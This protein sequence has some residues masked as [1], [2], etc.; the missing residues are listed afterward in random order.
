[1]RKTTRK[2][3]RAASSRRH[4]RAAATPARASAASPAQLLGDIRGLIEAA[5]MQTAQ[6]VNAGLVT[7]CWNIGKRIREDSLREKRAGY[8]EEIVLTLS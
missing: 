3:A 7:L 5:R 4:L 6:A 8:G 1:M 2:L